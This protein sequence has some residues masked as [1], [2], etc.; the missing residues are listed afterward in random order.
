[1]A[2]IIS[3]RTRPPIRSWTRCL[4][5]LACGPIAL[6][7][8]LVFA[9]PVAASAGKIFSPVAPAT[10]A[11]FTLNPGGTFAADGAAIRAVESSRAVTVLDA[12]DVLAQAGHA[13]S[14]GLCH[15][16]GLAARL[17]PSGFC[18]D[19]QDDTSDSYTAA[20]GWTPQGITGSYDAQPNGRYDN[21]TAYMASWHLDQD[22]GGAHPV[23]NEFA[24]VTLVNGD[25]GRIN[26]N[27]ML[28]V[29]P[30]LNSSG[31]GNFTATPATHADGIVWYGNSVFVA[32]G[33]WLQVYSLN[34]IWR[35]GTSQS[36]VGIRSGTSSARYSNYALPM[37]GEYLTTTSAGT[38][39]QAGTSTMPCLSSLSLDRT[40]QDGLVSAEYDGAPGGRIVRWPLDFRT[41]LPLVND[42]TGAGTTHATLAYSSPVL[43][44][45]GA[46]T[47]GTSWYM[48][49]DCPAGVGTHSGD[50][51]PYSCI[52][53][54]LPNGTPTVFTTSPVITEN[55][56]YSPSANR[57]WGINERINR[58]TGERVAFSIN[59]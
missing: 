46:A 30:T 12:D 17:D 42:G 14:A 39:C 28:L 43:H 33:R 6:T 49:G 1:M 27:H 19:K 57:I 52:Y 48:S 37:I 45:Q 56:G 26:Y 24:R 47:N 10:V 7:G 3:A 5:A 41:A 38:A 59:P 32:N 16:T 4:I 40:G 23:A 9:A 11:A 29:K 50:S 15:K 2:F 8:S 35:V 58:T 55:L 22:L 20:G 44:M 53:K 31:S 34:H 51:L 25:S 36:F 18:W 21:Q 54:T 13:G